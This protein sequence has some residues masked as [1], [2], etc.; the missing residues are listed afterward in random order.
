M[1]AYLW[2]D[3][4]ITPHLSY[5]NTFSSRK[6]ITVSKIGNGYYRVMI[7]YVPYVSFNKSTTVIASSYGSD[8]SY[9]SVEGWVSNKSTGITTV[10]IR[11]HGATSSSRFT[12]FFYS[13]ENILF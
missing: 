1:G 8:K 4:T 11:N 6:N 10:Y 7:P 12:L 5:Q 2:Y 3:L 13:N 9:V